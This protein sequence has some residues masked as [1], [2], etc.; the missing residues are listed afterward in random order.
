MRL[1]AAKEVGTFPLLMIGDMI[2]LEKHH[3][4]WRFVAHRHTKHDVLPVGGVGDDGDHDKRSDD[5]PTLRKMSSSSPY[6]MIN[7]TGETNN[8]ALA[9]WSGRVGVRARGR[10]GLR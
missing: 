2:Q 3:C 4:I 10:H 1:L 8:G 7:A 5:L 6:R 9:R